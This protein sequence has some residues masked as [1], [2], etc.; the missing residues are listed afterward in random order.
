MEDY[1]TKNVNET[2]SSKGNSQ[3]P[4]AFIYALGLNEVLLNGQ[5]FNIYFINI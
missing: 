5:W 2:A 4:A 3:G 1:S